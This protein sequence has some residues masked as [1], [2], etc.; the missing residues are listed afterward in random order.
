MAT[1]CGEVTVT[2]RSSGARGVPSLFALDAALHLPP[3]TSSD[4]LRRHVAQD[5]ALMRVDAATERLAQTTGGH[6]PT[7]QS[8]Q[9]V[10]QVVQDCE[11][12]SAMRHA[13]GAEASED[14]LVLTT[15]GTGMVRHQAD[16]REA[17]R[18][19]AARAR[20]TR[21][22]RLSPGETR[23]RKRMA[24]VASVYT[25]APSARSPAEVMSPDPDEG[26]RPTVHNKRVW[27]RVERDAEAVIDDRFDEAV[28]RDPTQQ[29]PWV[30]VVD[31]EPHQLARVHAAARRHQVSV[32]M[33]MDCMHVL[34]DLWEAAR[35]LAAGHA[36]AAE[37]GGQA[38]ALKVLQGQA[39]T[40]AAGMRRRATMRTFSPKQRAGG[41]TCADSLLHR[42]VSLRSDRFLAQGV[43]IAPG[44]IAGTCRHLITDRMDLTG[45]R[46]RLQRAEAVLQLRSLRSSGAFEASWRVH[47]QQ[48]L[49]RNHL[50]YYADPLFLDAD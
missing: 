38:R 7:R 11:A 9:V 20:P 13:Q 29:R 3:D 24:T 8:A 43:P 10:V 44:G 49:Q 5:V 12:F 14:L 39:R 42:Y 4:G 47:K 16:L 36:E 27:A 22:T 48:E 6:M 33:V 21:I 40:V 26:P 30:V 17:T 34:E 50:S 28:R 19:A 2:R 15:D 37:A 32:T 41:D 46:W 18:K 35:G 31:G 25:V 1:L 45:A 23:P